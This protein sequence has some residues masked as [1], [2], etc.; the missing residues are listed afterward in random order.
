[1]P[2][3]HSSIVSDS[4]SMSGRTPAVPVCHAD[5]VGLDA[6]DVCEDEAAGACVD[7]P[8]DR[9]YGSCRS[10]SSSD[11]WTSS[12]ADAWPYDT[13]VGVSVID[14]CGAV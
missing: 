3:P 4:S 14:E 5:D 7:A 6:G 9:I 11:E 10:S 12:M 2:T 8:T 1:M 13:C